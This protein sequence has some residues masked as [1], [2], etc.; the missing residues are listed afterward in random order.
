[1][2]KDNDTIVVNTNLRSRKGAVDEPVVQGKV[3]CETTA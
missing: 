2:V 1:M 3:S